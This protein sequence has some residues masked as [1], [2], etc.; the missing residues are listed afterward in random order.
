MPRALESDSA[1]SGPQPAPSLN[2]PGCRAPETPSASAVAGQDQSTEPDTRPAESGASCA[3]ANQ[4]VSTRLLGSGVGETDGQGITRSFAPIGP[5]EADWPTI[6]GYEILGVLGRGG[7][8]RVYKARQV[9]LKR[10][11]ALKVIL[12]GEDAE[13]DT[14]A[15]FREE[16]QA[17]ARLQHPN[18]VQIYDV[19]EQDGHPYFSL[20]LVAGGSLAQHLHGTALPVRQAAQF[21]ETLARAVHAAHQQG[22]IHRDLKPAN[23]LLAPPA[24]LAGE[25][26]G[27][28]DWVPKITDFG[29][30]KKLDDPAGLTL[31]GAIVGTPRY[32]APEQAAGRAGDVGP[33][34]DVYALG[35]ILHELL[36]GRTPFSGSLT[37]VLDQIRHVEPVP[38]RRLEPEIPPDLE[39]ICLKCLQKEPSKRYSSAA[40]LANDLKRFLNY[41]PIEARQVALFGRLAL[42]SRRHKQLLATSAILAAAIALTWIGAERWLI[43]RQTELKLEH[44]AR[45][46]EWKESQEARHKEVFE[47]ILS[48][49]AGS[50]PLSL[51][52]RLIFQEGLHDLAV[53]SNHAKAHGDQAEAAALDQQIKRAEPIVRR[54]TAELI[55]SELAG[56]KTP[57]VAGALLQA[58]KTKSINNLRQL[59]LAMHNYAAVH[60]YL[61]RPALYSKDGKPL[62]SWRVA[63]LPYL[64]ETPLFKKFHLD[65]PWDGPHNKPLLEYMPPSF[66]ATGE[67]P[68][69]Q[70]YTTY[71]QVLVGT[72]GKVGPA[73]EP[74]PQYRLRVGD[75]PD[76]SSN[77]LLIVEGASAVPWTKPEDLV[78][79]PARP[80]PKMGG[81]LYHDGFNACFADS[82]CRFLTKD[83]D[84][85]TLRAF[86]TRNG[87][88]PVNWSKIR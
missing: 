29:L 8:G 38:L 75:I 56:I 55:Q 63:V 72:N 53:R 43:Y 23:I 6:R 41:K 16:A 84:E 44:E 36:T 50:W 7:M 4:E 88:E 12:A 78:Y 39:T 68:S 69:S 33:A 34:T 22:V 9:S 87:G 14:V 81:G 15:R 20:E 62:L 47:K 52:E 45:D 74:D 65:E 64:G 77:T 49:G 76:G 54:L 85:A 19:G 60:G 26:A 2:Q 46:R 66:M 28:E 57:A 83:L 79:D 24:F 48:G 35:V 1:A 59:S 27:V 30:A 13:A 5:A 31:S 61:P 51:E 82:T 3:A 58:K 67:Q 21:V 18:I 42:W 37:Q 80:L 71:Y 70:P 25:R 32:M 73:F 17:L 10:L 86:C 40:A 11:V